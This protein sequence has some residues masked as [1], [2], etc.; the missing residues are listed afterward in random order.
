MISRM[1][2]IN[3]DEFRCSADGDT[4]RR[5][6]FCGKSTDTKPVEGVKNADIFYEMDTGNLYMFDE[7]NRTWLEQ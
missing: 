2:K 5:V 7:A 3:G 4:C 1:V 6:E